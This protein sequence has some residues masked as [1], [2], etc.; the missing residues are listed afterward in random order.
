MKTLIWVKILKVMTWAPGAKVMTFG[1]GYSVKS[2]KY[3]RHFWE[4]HQ[5]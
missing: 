5:K 2:P 3:Q 4:S 1:E